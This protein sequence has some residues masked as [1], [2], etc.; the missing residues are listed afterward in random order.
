MADVYAG[1]RDAPYSGKPMGNLANVAGAVVSL[2]LVA[3][4]GVWGYKLLVR[5]VSGV[6]VVRAISG[7]MREQPNDPGG[8]A[9]AHQG[10]A[11]NSVAAEGSAAAPADRLML[12]PEPVDVTDEDAAGTVLALNAA[13][14]AP[15]LPDVIHDDAVPASSAYNADV[16]G[17]ADDEAR[18]NQEASDTA[19][20]E[21]V[22]EADTASELLTN[23]AGDAVAIRPSSVEDL[24]AQIAS[25]TPPLSD[26]SPVTVAAPVAAPVLKAAIKG[27]LKRSLR[28]RLRPNGLQQAVAV[29]AVAAQAAPAGTVRDLDPA[30][31]GAGTRLAQ[32]GAFESPEIARKEWDRLSAR[33]GDFLHG[34]D[35]VI[36]KAQSGGRT[37]YRLRAHGFADLSDARR[38]CSAFVAE[39]VDCI[40]VVTR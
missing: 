33:F 10:L 35:R 22:A 21:E 29:A 26:L 3:G 39:K 40:P 8:M 18:M 19:A 11:V 12:A 7:P 16:V 23:A 28:P 31:I 6:P 1:G 32:L 13:R 37:F 9:A 30:S 14:S 4:V 27:G 38:F 17:G 5:D 20:T 36:E 15:R 34:K 24:V 2:A 25:D